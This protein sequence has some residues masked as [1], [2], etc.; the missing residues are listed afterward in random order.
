MITVDTI[1]NG[2]GTV[3]RSP[4]DAL[5]ELVV[6]GLG[7][8][9]E[10]SEVLPEKVVLY[11]SRP[12][13]KTV[14]FSGAP[15]DMLPLHSA[16]FMHNHFTMASSAQTLF[17][18]QVAR[19]TTSVASRIYLA[20]IGE[21]R[22]RDYFQLLLRLDPNSLADVYNLVEKGHLMASALVRVQ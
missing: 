1:E 6:Y 4:L 16:I 14:M 15:S 11:S 7:C 22:A 12:T 2:M 9:A 20:L 13:P 17:L 8:G 19:A 21:E 10:L 5:K 3:Q 18:G